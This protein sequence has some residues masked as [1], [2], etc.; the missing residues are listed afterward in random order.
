MGG[1]PGEGRTG[2]GRYSD[3]GLCCTWDITASKDCM[4]VVSALLA[5]RR[6]RGEK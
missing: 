2:E 1:K 5:E 3:G 4:C 6:V